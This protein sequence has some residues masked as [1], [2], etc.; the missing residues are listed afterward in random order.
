[1]RRR[2]VGLSVLAGVLATV[3]FGLPLGYLIARNLIN[4][5]LGEAERA[6]D[7]VA[8]AVSAGVVHG[9]PAPVFAPRH[10]DIRIG[11]Y[12]ARGVRVAGL[13]PPTADRVARQAARGRVATADD[14][15]GELVVA[16][17]VTDS[18]RAA[19]VVRADS[20]YSLVRAHIVE[21]WGVMLG[22]ATVAVAVVWLLARRAARRLATPLESLATAAEQLGNG[23]FS[24]R[25]RPSGTPEIDAAGSALNRTAARLGDLLARERAFSADASHQLRTPLTGLRLQLETALEQPGSDPRQAMIA[26]IAAADRLEQTVEDLLA[27]ARETR[28]HG[29]PLDVPTLVTDLVATYESVLRAAGRDLRVACDPVLPATPATAA[30]VRQVTGVLLDNAVVHGAGT[31]SVRVRDAGEALALDVADEGAGPPDPAALF[32]R[33]AAGSDDGTGAGHGIGLA[34][35]RALAEGEGGRLF[36]ARAAPPVFSLLLPLDTEPDP[37]TETD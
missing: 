23:D 4:G 20:D 13:G 12:D 35:A 36:L 11:L 24:V 7:S 34:L 6:A 1:V 25:T 32:S 14:V 28:P 17:P 16:V 31:V 2:I 27:L 18:T 15:R 9:D 10:G 19:G 3:L 29:V 33:R 21:S 8:I 22:L 26:A 5:E 37:G 30:A